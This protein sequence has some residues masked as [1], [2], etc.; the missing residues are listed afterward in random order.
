M[1]KKRKRH[2]WR[3]RERDLD[4]AEEER[5][6]HIDE[7]EEEGESVT[8]PDEIRLHQVKSNRRTAI[9]EWMRVVYCWKSLNWFQINLQNWVL[10]KKP[11]VN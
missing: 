5:E 3:R 10:Q 2:R 8:M 4:E 11:R 7:K 6:S 9:I 1:N